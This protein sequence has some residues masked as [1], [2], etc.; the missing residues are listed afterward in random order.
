MGNLVA[1]KS[2]CLALRGGAIILEGNLRGNHE[3]F[4]KWEK[5]AED[6]RLKSVK[7]DITDLNGK[8]LT[9]TFNHKSGLKSTEGLLDT[10]KSPIL[11]IEET[12]FTADDISSYT[13]GN[14]A[15][16]PYRRL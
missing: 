7:V 13:V 12:I 4:I 3:D 16:Y 2:H 8:Y 9:I 6:A 14:P 1:V 10:T 5:M 15:D 11:K